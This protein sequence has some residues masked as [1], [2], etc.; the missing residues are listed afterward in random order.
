MRA[1]SLIGKERAGRVRRQTKEPENKTFSFSFLA[2]VFNF[3]LI[4][5]TVFVLNF[6]LINI[7]VVCSVRCDES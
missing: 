5:I 1:V 3:L 4:D 6:F 7:T 2:S